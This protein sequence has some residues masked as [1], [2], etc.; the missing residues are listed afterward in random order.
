MDIG[1][2]LSKHGQVPLQGAAIIVLKYHNITRGMR[3]S[4]VHRPSL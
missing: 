3:R 4:D 1:I 2:S